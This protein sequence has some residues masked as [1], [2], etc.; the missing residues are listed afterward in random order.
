VAAASLIAA[1]SGFRAPRPPAPARWIP[2]RWSDAA[3]GGRHEPRAALLV[4]VTLDGVS[5]T[6]YLQLDTG[7]G[8]PRWYEVPLRQLLPAALGGAHDSAP[9][10]VVLRGRV[11]PVALA[12]D[13][14]LVEKGF[15]DS[16]PPAD[17]PGAAPRVIG[18]LGL[19][20]FRERRLLLDFPR[21][22]IAIADSGRALPAGAPPAFSYIPSRYEHGYLFVPFTVDGRPVDDFFFDSGASAVP[23]S[24][25]AA[26]WRRLT[27][28]T[29]GERDN[30]RL[31]LSSWGK[32]REYVAAPVAGE[33]A[34]GPHRVPR[35]LVFAPREPAD[36]TDFF[37]DAPFH[38]GG[39]FGNAL[40]FDTAVIVDLPN[41][42]FGIAAR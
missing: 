34:F 25:T 19:R 1:V 26:M 15:G 2:C 3:F 18:T 32:L 24:T 20:F 31:T 42:R 11:G 8:W 29:G 35:P 36:G 5:G 28:R 27:G 40:F 12:S 41:R 6:Y 4:P 37:A 16:L 21:G 13:T 30:V 33:V 17:A 39:L 10:E 9:D 22:R 23:L 38:V 14:F 7:A